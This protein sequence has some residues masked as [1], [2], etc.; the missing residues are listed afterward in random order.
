LAISNVAG[1]TIARESDGGIYQRSGPE[2][3]VASTKAFTG[4][5]C[6]VAM[7]AIYFARLRDMGFSD[8][9][10]CVKALR[11]LP[12]KVDEVLKRNAHIASVAQKY[13]SH[14]HF[15]FLGRQSMFPIALEGALKLKEVS[16]IHAEGYPAAELKHGPIALID[17]KYPSLFLATDPDVFGK[18]VGNMMEVKARGGS[19]VAVGVDGAHFPEGSCDDILW[20]PS[21]H[22]LVLP[23]VATIPLQLLAYHVARLRHCDVDKPRNLAKSVTVE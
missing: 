7:L 19:V 22:P 15:L 4:Q 10:G 18:T 16:Y 8:G 12:E 9:A 21:V 20:I 23:I 2:I 11:E 3:G 13:G 17:E 1:S 6:V 14:D 5:L